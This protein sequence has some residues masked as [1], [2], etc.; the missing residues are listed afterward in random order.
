[1]R[2]LLEKAGIPAEQY[3]Y[4]DV[5]MHLWEAE[6]HRIRVFLATLVDFVL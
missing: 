6:C 4:L 2:M 3:A 1:M 5:H